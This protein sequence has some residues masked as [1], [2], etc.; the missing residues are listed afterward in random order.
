[1]E[2][3]IVYICH[4]WITENLFPIAVI[5][6]VEKVYIISAQ[7]SLIQADGDIGHFVSTRAI[8]VEH[9]NYA[10]DTQGYWLG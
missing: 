1:M 2:R 5:P 9:N 10:I 4:I 6:V 7:Y 3:I 8:T